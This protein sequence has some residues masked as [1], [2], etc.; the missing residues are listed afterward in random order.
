MVFEPENALKAVE[1]RGYGKVP[2]RLADIDNTYLNWCFIEYKSAFPILGKS[3]S[4]KFE[5]PLDPYGGRKYIN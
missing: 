5:I 2:F 3:F 4:K 1:I